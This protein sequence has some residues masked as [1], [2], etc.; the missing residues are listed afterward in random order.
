MNSQH[1]SDIAEFEV[2]EVDTDEVT[3]PKENCP[4]CESA[5]SGNYRHSN[6]KVRVSVFSDFCWFPSLILTASTPWIP[7]N[8]FLL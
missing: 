1:A 6:L 5:F 2:M 8:I 7:R 3:E 4:F